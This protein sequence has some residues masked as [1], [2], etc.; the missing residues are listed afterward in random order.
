LDIQ[1]ESFEVLRKKGLY[2]K[3]IEK[4]EEAKQC[5]LK[6]I[7]TDD[8]CEE[9]YFNIGNIYIAAFRDE[10]SDFSNDTT[11]NIA[12]ENFAKAIELNDQYVDAFYN[13]GLIYEHRG[14]KKKAI[15]FY[16]QALVIEPMHEL[17]LDALRNF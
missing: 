13:S 6:I 7:A 11:T 14:D 16:H 5:F 1:A 2:L 17:S 12:L 15:E 10:M 3:D 8:N 4:Y 9:C